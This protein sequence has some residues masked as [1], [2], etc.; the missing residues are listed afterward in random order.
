MTIDT[1]DPESVEVTRL[2][3]SSISEFNE[4]IQQEYDTNLDD[5]RIT[6]SGRSPAV[7]SRIMD[8]VSDNENT[9]IYGNFTVSSETGIAKSLDIKDIFIRGDLDMSTILDFI[10]DFEGLHDLRV[11]DYDMDKGNAE[12]R[13]HFD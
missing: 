13:I 5:L 2:R 8:W 9:E 1:H 3:I 11:E 4:M 12:L 6:A 10:S 7:V